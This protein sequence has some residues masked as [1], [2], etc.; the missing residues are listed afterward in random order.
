[1]EEWRSL[2]EP[3]CEVSSHGRACVG[4]LILPGSKTAGGYRQIYIKGQPWYVHRLVTEAF[5][6]PPPSPRHEVNHKNCVRHDNRI[7]NLEWVTRSENVLHSIAMGGRANWRYVRG[8]EHGRTTLTES[9]VRRLRSLRADGR[10]VSLLT[11]LFGVS[12]STIYRIAK[13]QSWGHVA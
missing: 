9:D 6:G 5:L 1:M 4:G 8:E 10:S 3:A 7:D 2:R 11:Q 12:R 13:R